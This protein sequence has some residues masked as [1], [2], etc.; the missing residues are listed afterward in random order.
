MKKV[1]DWDKYSEVAKEV[2][3]E[4]CILLENKNNA[5]PLKKGAKV[6]IFG[7]IQNSYYKSGT[8]S[9]GMVN[10]SK[11]YNIVE[12]LELSNHVEINKD[13]QKVYADWEEENPIDEGLGWGQERWSQ[14]EM[15][16][17]K[18]IVSDAAKVSDV[19][20]VI[21]GRTAG[22]DKDASN[23]AGSYALT[24]IEL[25]MIKKVRDGF[26]T[27]IVL[28]NV[29]SII[30]MSF[31]D[32]YNPDAV[33]YVWQGGMLGGLGTADVLI[34]KANPSGKL[35]DT[36]AYQIEDY[37]SNAYFGVK[38]ENKY[39]E[40]IFVGYRY[41]E[42]FAKDKVH[43]PFGYGLSYTNFAN[44]ISSFSND[45]SNKKV[46]VEVTVKNTGDVPGKEVIQIY[47]KAPQGKLGKAERVIVDFDKTKNLDCGETQK[48][49]FEIDY[50][51]FA[52][53]DD[54][55]VTGK[56]SAFVLEE[57]TY[58]VYAGSDVRS[59]KLVGEFTLDELL[60]IKQCEEALAPVVP[61]NRFHASKGEKGVVLNLEATPLSTIS[62]EERRLE[63]L[64]KEIKQVT[65]SD[66]IL[67]DVLQNKATMEAF[68]AQLSD[69]DLTCLARGEGMG[70]ILVTPGTA[71]A[72]GGVSDR[73]LNTFK[74]PSVCCDDGPSGMRLDCGIKAFSLPN[75]VMV[76]STFNR[77][78]ITKL[79]AFTGLEMVNNHVENLLGPGMNIHRHPLNGRNFEYFSE[80]P[81][82]T[83]EMAVAMI[84]GLKN[85]GVT[86]TVKH[87]C[88]NNQEYNRR[89]HNSIISERALREIYLKGFEIAVKSGLADSVMT[90]YGAVN[91]TFTA[92]SYDL[93]TTILREDW[94]FTGVVMTDW[95]A[96]IGF[97]GDKNKTDFAAMVRSQNDM[98]MVC[99]DGST[100]AS[101]DNL[102]EA[103]AEGNLTRAELQRTAMNVCSFAMKTEAMNRL[104][105]RGTEV[106]IINRPKDES[107]L[108]LDQVESV[109]LDGDLTID[110]TYQESKANTNY[111]LAF[112]VKK[113]GTYEITLVASSDLN[114][115]AQLPVTYFYQNIPMLSFTFHGTEG[116]EDSI[117]KEFIFAQRFS[118][119]RLFVA[120]NGIKLKEIHFKHISDNTEFD[121]LEGIE[122][123]VI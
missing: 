35:T 41:F 50:D 120:R 52:S 68:I 107:D 28:L 88:G 98:Y 93:N 48:F 34:G 40:D 30:D 54:G 17:T 110:L 31:V 49:V 72:F 15:P 11:V 99:P 101:G 43:Y 13:L 83:G 104:M 63:R 61:F 113:V 37:P 5:L 32:L 45:L 10:V 64:P 112:D 65:S 26:G 42:T 105:G 73:L 111:V 55:G 21:I 29:G 122:G 8:G 59:A 6:S 44:D 23:T 19:A 62:V 47:I 121:F 14:D 86:G 109:I 94:G 46:S 79:Y 123:I 116:K 7:R 82:V 71:S 2:I 100:N 87:F 67:D 96:D 78:L 103:L 80:D 115:L 108:E 4:G 60:V 92:N 84:R 85:S 66:I 22:E 77:E 91:G 39:S 89:D 69:D 70:S 53:Y 117:T 33:M 9:G 3:S 51:R 58:E 18:D 81:Y 106:E 119:T 90:T 24:D 97:S 20:I 57:G 95:W 1:L 76:A 16:L 25:D 12:G 36:I 56:K 74:I 118:I 114:P 27:V 75:G 102:L 38:E